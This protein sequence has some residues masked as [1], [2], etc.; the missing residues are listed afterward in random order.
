M[1]FDPNLLFYQ[2]AQIYA[3]N[4]DGSTR[5]TICNEG[6]SR[7]FSGDQE[8]L[9]SEGA[10]P[11]RDILP[12][13]KV[14]SYNEATG[15][16][17]LAE[18]LEAMKFDNHKR[19]IRITLTSGETITATEDHEFFF[20]GSWI[21][22]KRLL[23]SSHGV[24]NESK[25]IKKSIKLE[26]I[27]SAEEVHL[28][29]VF[30]LRID[31]NSNY[32]LKAGGGTLVHNSSKT[33][34]AFHFIYLFCAHNPGKG[35]DIYIMRDT[36]TNC[37]DYTFKEFKKCMEVIGVNLNYISA[38]QKPFVD[39]FGNNI[40]F[41]GLDSEENTEGFPSDILF[42]NEALETEKAKIAGLKMRCRKLLLM[43]WTQQYTPPWCFDMEGKPDVHFTR[44]THKQKKHLQKSVIK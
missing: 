39:L 37:K 31:K 5:V 14:L 21:S 2:M 33:W 35:N 38:G 12:G 1:A 24:G 9:T 6:S 22:L 29:E 17:E 23:S 27:V 4:Y 26:D 34:D 32:F 41:R 18:V 43:D 25:K 30:D 13:E 11:I 3:E 44:S 7:C 28:E 19:V 20:E 42:I 8:V 16:E 15:V 10:K 40:Y 36:L